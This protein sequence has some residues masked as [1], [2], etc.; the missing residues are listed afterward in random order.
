VPSDARHRLPQL[1]ES[2]H[3]EFVNGLLT[4]CPKIRDHLSNSG[5]YWC[6]IAERRY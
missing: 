5:E 6:C 1:A 2:A 3:G 4:A